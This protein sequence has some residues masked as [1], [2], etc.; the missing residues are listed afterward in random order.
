MKKTLY[1]T[2]FALFTALGGVQTQ[3][4]ALDNDPQ[5]SAIL[6][7]DK[8]TV[9]LGSNSEF[10]S[11]AVLGNVNYIIKEAPSWLQVVKEENGNLTLFSNY[12]TDHNSKRSGVVVLQSQDGT[13][14]HSLVVEQS[15]NNAVSSLKED[16][17]LGVTGVANQAQN[18]EG[19]DKSYD[20]D[21]TTIYHS[22]WSN[23]KFPV[24]LTYTLNTPSQVDYLIYTPRQSG[25]NGYF[26]EIVVA[27]TIASAPENWIE[28]TK[29]D[30]G[31]SAAATQINFGDDGVANVSKVRITVNSGRGGFASCAE[32]GFYQR[33]LETSQLLKRF[34]TDKLCTELQPGVTAESAATITQP[35]VKQLVYSLLAGNYST[36][37]RVGEFEAY[38]N[39]ASLATELKTTAY[40]AYENPTGIYFAKDER[41]A[42]FVEGIGNTSVNLIV[43]SFGQESYAGEGQPQSSYP[44]KNGMNV[45]TIRNRGNGYIS[46]YSNSFATDPKVRIH[47]AM[48]K[49]NGYFDLAR[50]DDNAYWQELLA[51]A[52][53]DILDVRTPR[54]QVACPVDRLKT[55]CPKKGVELATIYEN[56]IYRHRQIMGLTYFGNEPKNRQ[57]ARPVT[58]G[59]YAD[60]IGAAAAYNSFG[61]WT[62][63]DN[64]GFWGFAHELGHN[65]QVRPGL[66]WVGCGETT[67]NIYSTWVEHT[68]GNGYHRLEDET[69][70]VNDYKGVRGGRFQTHLEEGVRKGVA[71]QLQEGP[72]YNGATPTEVSVTD[73]DYEGNNLGTVTTT[74]RNY[75]HFV[76]V[77]PLWQ[78]TLYT[79]EAE[80]HPNAFGKVTE[81]VRTY[82]NESTLTDGQLQ[83]KF[84][85][86]FCDSTQTN[87]LPFF[88]KAGMLKPIN[89]YIEDY[90][91]GWL[92]IS[93]EMINQ[94]KSYIGAKGY[95]EPDAAL[96]YINAYNWRVFKDRAPLTTTAT[97]NSGCTPLTNGR[98]QVD[99]SV[100]SNAV[101]YETY[102]A[103]GNLL[104]I[105]MFGLGDT[106]K[107]SRYTQVLWPNTATEKAAYIMAVG[108]DGTRVKCYQP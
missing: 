14:T 23:T 13:Y 84:M 17:R 25:T 51:N 65:N 71:W 35:Y 66:R 7:T 61:E 90:T 75:D 41:I 54:M 50:G 102:D 64:F 6:Y 95:P 48:A 106:Q 36:K 94:L 87:F 26:G 60:A 24:V 69:T 104:R 15:A 55:A 43:K 34:F 18:G 98:V 105:T 3:N 22:P 1:T 40:C 63:P 88:E 20:N 30:L 91:P 103:S 70:G 82:P 12:H 99:N 29:R 81:G 97:L 79:E 73:K 74:K 52:C 108:Y 19:I 2:L 89:A 93:E 76:K 86:S 85:R 49:E 39:L 5:K 33:N 57:F 72:D 80:R 27:Y 62:N 107:S 92:K 67:N 47:F 96:N 45:L 59:M 42:L 28:L 77:V 56:T 46:Y 37:Y 16:T 68:L 21:F 78:L 9:V 100:W 10:T 4:L 83:I 101:G 8:N 11:V 38:R 31:E 44:L 58:S 53:S 32:M